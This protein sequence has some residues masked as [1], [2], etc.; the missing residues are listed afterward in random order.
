MNVIRAKGI[1]NRY[2]PY[3]M[4]FAAVLERLLFPTLGSIESFPL[5]GEGVDQ[6]PDHYARTMKMLAIQPR[7]VERCSLDIVAPI[8]PYTI[9]DWVPVRKHPHVCGTVQTPK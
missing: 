7:R 4:L 1:K 6:D 9:D 8:N 3:E 2:S 5:R